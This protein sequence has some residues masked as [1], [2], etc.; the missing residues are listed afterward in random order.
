MTDRD[1]SQTP[2]AW[3]I[4]QF[5]AFYLDMRTLPGKSRSVVVQPMYRLKST[6]DAGHPMRVTQA[7]YRQPERVWL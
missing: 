6:H 5:E 7:D 4:E 2:D 1:A 3:L